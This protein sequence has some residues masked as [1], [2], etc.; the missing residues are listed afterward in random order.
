[1]SQACGG[2]PFDII[3]RAP[4]ACWCCGLHVRPGSPSLVPG[5]IDICGSNSGS[6][7]NPQ[8]VIFLSSPAPWSFHHP[9]IGFLHLPCSA[10]LD[11]VIWQ[12]PLGGAPSPETFRAVLLPHGRVYRSCFCILRMRGRDEVACAQPFPAESGYAEVPHT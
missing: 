11:A 4:M 8:S 9:S 12:C 1:M 10:F 5:G 3:F 7:K 2:D 6:V